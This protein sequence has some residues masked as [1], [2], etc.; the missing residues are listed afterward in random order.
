MASLSKS[1][2]RRALWRRTGPKWTDI[3]T[4]I[5]V[6]LA[7]W[8]FRFYQTS[9]PDLPELTEIVVGLAALILIE[10]FR[11]IVL[12]PNAAFNLYLDAALERDRFRAE[13]EGLRRTEFPKIVP[14]IDYVLVGEMNLL[15][16]A[17]GRYVNA[18]YYLL[19]V[20]LRNT[21]AP[22]SVGDYSVTVL[23]KDGTPIPS[24]PIQWASGASV[25]IGPTAVPLLETYRLE[26]RSADPI[27]TGG[28]EY[29]LITL[30]FPERTGHEMSDASIAIHLGMRD[31]WNT[32]YV[33]RTTVTQGRTDVS[34]YFARM[35]AA[36]PVLPDDVR[37]RLMR[38][39]NAKPLDEA[40]AETPSR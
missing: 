21:G 11:W 12:A 14:S 24:E 20:S 5:L 31:A 6:G 17:S 35:S 16:G 15:H 2:F 29:G 10:G 38:S 4:A 33:C 30:T 19:F 7:P 28:V 13:I 1:E 34:Q 40:Q 39:P 8:A 3:V 9:R 22:S 18:A 23:G 27:P 37:D 25:Q 36:A 26:S 32:P